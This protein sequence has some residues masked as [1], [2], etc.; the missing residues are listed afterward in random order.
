M[1]AAMKLGAVIIPATPLL[2]PADLVDRV[3]RGDVRHVV[4]RRRACRQVRRRCPATTRASRSAS[5]SPAGGPTTTPTARRTTFAPDG[6]TRRDGPAAALLH[7]RHDREAQARRAHPRVL[8]R[9]PPL[10]DVLDRP[11]AGR[12]PPERL[13]AGLGQARV[14]QRLRAVERAGQRDRSTTPPRFDAPALLDA[15]ARCRRD[16]VLR[17]ADG[18]A[19]ADPGGPRALE[20]RAARGRSARAS[21][22]TPR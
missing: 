9:R 11:R 15:M 12:R 14:E 6:P 20:G 4:A 1:L 16:H 17:A 19:D 8:S 21:R 7:L 2:G 10:D 18:L 22:S 13:L 3:Q 5:R